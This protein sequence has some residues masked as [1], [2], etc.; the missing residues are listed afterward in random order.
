M[1]R[2]I[3]SGD[4]DEV[5]RL[6]EADPTLLKKEEGRWHEEYSNEKMTPV[7]LAAHAGKL[8]MV[9]LLVGK[10]ANIHATHH[11]ISAWRPC[12]APPN[13]VMRRWWPVCLPMVR[14]LCA[15][16]TRTGRPSCGHL[17]EAALAWCSS[18]S[19]TWGN[20]G[21]TRELDLDV[22]R[23]GWLSVGVMRNNGFGDSTLRTAVTSGHVGMV[24]LLVDH[25]GTQ[26]LHERDGIGRSLLHHA[27]N[28]AKE[29]MVAY[30]LGKSLRPSIT[31][32]E[33]MTPLM[34][35]ARMWSLDSR[36]M[37]EMLLSHMHSHELD[38]RDTSWGQTA[39]HWAVFQNRPAHVRALLVAGADASIV[40]NRRRTPRVLAGEGQRPECVAVFEV[41][42][43][44]G[45]SIISRDMLH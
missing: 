27:V 14:I 28:S 19:S 45:F 25:L 10:G 33:G 15:W 22:P 12:T 3:H 18:F 23:W 21:W 20:R 43:H 1:F 17:G 38:T 24:T 11:R 26:A 16:I 7:L 6:L 8:D 31:D 29:D 36:R 35:C 13:G 4:V 30:L 32:N 9:N 39:L 41:G 42:S 37:Q 40:D 5:L 44:M 34:Y 2:S